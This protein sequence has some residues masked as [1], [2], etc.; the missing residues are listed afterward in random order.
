M[1]HMP[2]KQ[3]IHCFHI[4]TLCTLTGPIQ[5]CTQGKN[6]QMELG[7]IRASQPYLNIFMAEC[8]ADTMVTRQALT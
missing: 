5:K 1:S 3:L 4:S 6:S 8:M 7:M 2:S